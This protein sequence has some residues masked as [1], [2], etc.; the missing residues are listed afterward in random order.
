MNLRILKK[1]SKRAAPL[2]HALGDDR[3]QFLAGDSDSYTDLIGFD[4]KHWKRSRTSRFT[5]WKGDIEYRTRRGDAV[6]HLS[7]SYIHPWPGTPMVG[8]L[9]GYMEPEWEECTAWDSLRRLVRDHYQDVVDIELDGAADF[10]FI[11]LR[12]LRTPADFLRAVPDML[13]DLEKDHA[14]REARQRSLW[15]DRAA[16]VQ[17]IANAPAQEVTHGA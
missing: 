4:R 2:L 5:G 14:E 8:A 7:E 1:L 10:D 6:V 11:N 16:P 9:E 17:S 3:S 15:E 12:R 13:A